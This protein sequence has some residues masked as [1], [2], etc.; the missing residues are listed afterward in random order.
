MYYYKMWITIKDIPFNMEVKHKIFPE[1]TLI[2]VEDDCFLPVDGELSQNNEQEFLV[3]SNS[4]VRNRPIRTMLKYAKENHIT[5]SCPEI[6]EISLNRIIELAPGNAYPAISLYFA[7]LG[8][9]FSAIKNLLKEDYDEIYHRKY[10]YRYTNKMQMYIERRDIP[11]SLMNVANDYINKRPKNPIFVINQDLNRD[12]IREI[13]GMVGSLPAHT[14]QTKRAMIGIYNPSDIFNKDILDDFLTLNQDG[15]LNICLLCNWYSKEEVIRYMQEAL[16]TIRQSDSNPMI[17]LTL[18][19][20][21]NEYVHAN[22]DLFHD[23]EV[24]HIEERELSREEALEYI[25]KEA[26]D[27]EYDEYFKISYLE[28]EFESYSGRLY[29]RDLRDFFNNWKGKLLREK[30][31]RQYK[32]I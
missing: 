6:D 19:R 7:S 28:Q 10:L 13:S 24:F 18:P 9:D 5:I 30:I 3:F 32:D 12:I 31:Y 4:H 14:K 8:V 16:E 21:M 23:Y 2:K 29:I 20:Y 1:E 25:L 15:I 11:F 26:K 17:I 22:M 27:E